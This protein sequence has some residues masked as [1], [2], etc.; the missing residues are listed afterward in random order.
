MSNDVFKV[1]RLDDRAVHEIF[2]RAAEASSTAASAEE[3]T[4]EEYLEWLRGQPDSR[5]IDEKVYAPKRYKFCPPK[6]I[7]RRMGR[8][9]DEFTRI[10][11][12]EHKQ[13]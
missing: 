4:H 3:K 13:R 5:V 8:A 6:R 11:E 12:Q 10:Q 9:K 1:R 7:L 2:M